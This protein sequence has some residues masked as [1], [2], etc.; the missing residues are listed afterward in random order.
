MKLKYGTLQLT[1]IEIKP[2][3]AKFD[4]D[5]GEV[6]GVDDPTADIEYHREQG[7]GMIGFSI[8]ITN[9]AKTLL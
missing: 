8:M 1:P 5:A 2:D 6:V 9:G 3:Q 4:L 7:H